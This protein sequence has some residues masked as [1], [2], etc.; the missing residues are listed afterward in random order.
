M[1]G[2]GELVDT[3]TMYIVSS[4]DNLR[5]VSAA[6]KGHSFRHPASDRA[7]TPIAGWK[8]ALRGTRVR[9]L[10]WWKN[11]IEEL[12]GPRSFPIRSKGGRALCSGCDCRELEGRKR[13]WRGTTAPA[14]L[15]RRI[16]TVTCVVCMIVVEIG[17]GGRRQ[18]SRKQKSTRQ[19]HPPPSGHPPPRGERT[20]L[21][22]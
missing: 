11:A 19:F 17:V 21:L 10:R 2:K 20:M 15:G 6:T 8:R 18:E 9:G 5:A 13:V 14:G 4:I 12:L 22:W 3:T 1:H 7:G 16:Q